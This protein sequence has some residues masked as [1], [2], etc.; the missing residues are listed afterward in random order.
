MSIIFVKLKQ[1][2]SNSKYRKVLS[3]DETIYRRM[4]LIINSCVPY[5]P[6]ATLEEGEWFYVSEARSQDYTNGLLSH[7]FESV[8]FDSLEMQDFGAIDFLFVDEHE[9]LY[10]QKV[11]KAKLVARKSVLCIGEGFQYKQDRQELVIND[12]PDAIYNRSE[13]RLYFRRLESITSIFKGIDQLFREATDE[14][15]FDFLRNDFISLRADYD[16]SDVKTPNRKRIALAKNSLERLTEVDRGRIFSY[17]GEYCPNLSQDNGAFEIGTEDELKMLLYG[18]EQRFY[19]T[20][21]GGEK[22]LANSVIP[23]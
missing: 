8:D 12:L 17:I 1:R 15:V 5:A 2:T 9:G 21:V 19:T 18:I 23:L 11:S 14:E 7:Q 13:D 4:N 22:R 20:P 16:V 10:F 3:T 6:S